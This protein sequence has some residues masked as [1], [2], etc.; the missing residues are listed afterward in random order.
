MR[1]INPFIIPALIVFLIFMAISC[2]A[3][4][5]IFKDGVWVG[6][7]LILAITSLIVYLYTRK[8]YKNN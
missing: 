7:F 6:L 1:K 8:F 5:V 2:D 3:F 4:E